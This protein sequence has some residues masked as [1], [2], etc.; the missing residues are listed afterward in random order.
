MQRSST[1]LLPIF[2]LC[3]SAGA[4][5]AQTSQGVPD[6]DLVPKA[7]TAISYEVNGGTTH[8]E[9]AGTSLKPLASGD[10]KVKAKHG[11][12]EIEV[13]VANL[14]QPEALGTEFLT[15]VLWAASPDGRTTNLGEIITDK[16]GSSKTTVTAPLQSFALFIT[17]E[18]Y[19]A[20]RQPSEEIV[21][22]N[23]LEKGSKGK[24]VV[25]NDYRLMR[26]AQYARM[27]NPLALT[28]DLK[29][30]PLDVYEARN[31]VEIAR[32]HG[33]DKYAPEIF[34]NAA[35]SLQSTE[36]ALAGRKNRKVIVT[37]A[38]QTV[39][40]AEDA[41]ALT[42]QK[43]YQE[44]V[45]SEREAA[46]AASKQ[47]AEAKAAADAAA[48]Q[49]QN[50]QQAQQQ[51]ELAAAK[52]AQLKAEADA[53]AA[54]AQAANEDAQRSK[55]A[56]AALRAQLLEQ[57][58]TIL[59]T[60]DSPRGLVVNIGDV[61]FD[62]GKFNLRQ[63]AREKLA[64]FAGIVLAHPGLNLAVEG[65]TDIT[66]SDELNQ[67]L[68]EDRA[69]AVRSY[70]VQQGLADSNISA[71]GLGKADPV[72]DNGTAA[73]RQLNRRVEIIISGE[74]IGQKIGQ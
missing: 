43:K 55:G 41:R 42:E 25:V 13:Q 53:A 28:L 15:F 2:T 54:R 40:F 30:T 4:A 35:S 12:T 5:A 51:A 33:A 8:I 69:N 39:Q 68:S 52:Q 26:S 70:L 58:N 3:L 38:R 24:T 18:P 61:L 20:V 74:V 1:V 9:L 65:H 56:A 46:A 60:H 71:T 21:L 63:T 73:G 67:K 47:Q 19:F 62:T 57:F 36:D 23:Q 34:A 22:E 17:A 64:R 50:A 27:N 44:H 31:A 59:E 7:V 48:V 14:T 45:A 37:D 29:S 49:Q 72:A 16:S 11:A 32:S 6:T 10:A 66:G